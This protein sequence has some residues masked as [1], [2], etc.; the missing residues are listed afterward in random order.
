MARYEDEEPIRRRSGWLIPLAVFVVTFALSAAIL[1]F[2]LAPRPTT[3]AGE[4]PSP[5]ARGDIVMLRIRGV[6]L[7][8]PAN[9]LVYESARQGGKRA[10]LSMFALLPDFT[11]YDSSQA[12]EFSSNAPDSEVIYMLLR[13][14]K[15]NF[16]ESER[17]KRIYMN[18]VANPA[19]EPGPFGLTRYVF[20]DDSGYRAEDLFVGDTDKGPVVMRCVRLSQDVV[21][22]S[23]LRDVQISPNVAL[24]YRFKRSHLSDWKSIAD[25]TENLIK[26]FRAA[27]KEP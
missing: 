7:G 9:Y 25:G 18:Y 22:P 12:S 26:K 8:V 16:S 6:H 13:E 11:G 24:T 27:F 1:V 23:C 5:T 4:Q 20:R 2:Y 3:F 21:S 15:L 14:E 10:D 19:G 17:L